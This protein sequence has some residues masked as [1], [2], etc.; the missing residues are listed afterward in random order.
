MNKLGNKLIPGR[1]FHEDAFPLELHEEF[2]ATQVLQDQVQ[3][4]AS[5]KCIDQVDNKR[6]LKRHV[7][8]MLSSC[9]KIL[10]INAEN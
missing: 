1:V 3:L 6:M 2:T 4:L 10:K 7:I 5:L 8:S 9:T